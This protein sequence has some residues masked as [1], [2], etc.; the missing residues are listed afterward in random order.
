MTS[1]RLKERDAARR[2]EHFLEDGAP[3]ETVTHSARET[4]QFGRALAKKLVPPCLILLQGELGSGKTTLAKGIVTGLGAAR[5]EEVTSP[6]FTLV[7]EYGGEGRVYHIDLYRVETAQELSTLGLD[8][9]FARDAVVLV[10]WGEKL[11]ANVPRPALEIQ[12]EY[13]E[14]DDRRITVKRLET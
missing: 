5:E 11:G 1:R 3:I 6:S 13:A 8:D 4:Q 7:H 10:E 2:P 14:N 12:L 9:I